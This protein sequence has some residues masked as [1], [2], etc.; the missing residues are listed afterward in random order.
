MEP[1]TTSTLPLFPLGTVLFP[2]MQ[3]PLHIFEERYR[4]MIGTCLA[5]G[6]PFGVVLI[7]EGSEVGAPAIPET[8][9]TTAV[10][11]DHRTLPGG[12]MQIV[13]RGQSRFRI[14]E[15]TQNKPYLI[16]RVRMLS[17]VDEPL[18]C[19]AA[20]EASAEF[21]MCLRDFARLG[22]GPQN[23]P[24]DIAPHTLSYAIGTMLTSNV[25]LPKGLA[26]AWLTEDSASIRLQA[27]LPVLRAL[28]KA[29]AEKLADDDGP[30]DLGL[31]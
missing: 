24:F 18:P 3:L 4:D 30:G 25:K 22:K 15:V 11:T 9:G 7:K 10:I 6:T 31:N 2:G 8:V 19:A 28:N 20:D 27:M 1:S 26:Q 5:Q 23:A 21:A 16:G 14:E 12:R 13:A 17:D 29:L